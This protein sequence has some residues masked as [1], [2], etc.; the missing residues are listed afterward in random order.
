MILLIATVINNTS[1]ITAWANDENYSNIFVRQLETLSKPRD[2]LI[3]FSGSGNSENIV[4]V[5]NWAVKNSINVIAFIGQ[6]GGIM[7]TI[8]GI[9][10]IH[11]KTDMQHSEDI[12]LL[13][14]H[15]LVR[16]IV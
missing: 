1:L 3:L 15:L 5:A 6:D 4:N 10:Q 2:I 14:G 11:T 13:M 9:T 7:S 12:H 8:K 16:M